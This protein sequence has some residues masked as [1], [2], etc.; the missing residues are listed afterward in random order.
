[1]R[2][3]TAFVY[4]LLRDHAVAG[5]LEVTAEDA[6]TIARDPDSHAAAADPHLLAW[7]AD[8][9]ERLEPEHQDPPAVEG[10]LDPDDGWTVNEIAVRDLD[11][12]PAVEDD[13]LP[14]PAAPGEP[15]CG[16]LSASGR[17]V[18]GL[19]PG[20]PGDHVSDLALGRDEAIRP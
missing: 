11:P 18:C 3:L 5:A 16:H 17:L 10:D 1:M 8:L 4:L 19:E 12:L 20:H 14:P 9:A 15:T 7:A 6:R 13:G 2:P